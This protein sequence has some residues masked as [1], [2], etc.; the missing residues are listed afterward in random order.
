MAEP[1]YVADRDKPY[2]QVKIP[3]GYQ[4]YTGG[5]GEISI[6]IFRLNPE[7][8]KNTP[9]VIRANEKAEAVN[10]IMAFGIP[11]AMAR[12]IADAGIDSTNAGSL[13]TNVKPYDS[14]VSPA[15][16]SSIL[17][18]TGFTFGHI[19]VGTD[20]T[21]TPGTALGTGTVAKE[22]L[23]VMDGLEKAPTSFLGSWNPTLSVSEQKVGFQPGDF[24]IGSY[25]D[26]F[27]GLSPDYEG[28]KNV[29]LPGIQKMADEA[30][31][32]AAATEI[33]RKTDA[34]EHAG[35]DFQRLMIDSVLYTKSPT[36]LMT[37]DEIAVAQANGELSPIEQ[38]LAEWPEEDRTYTLEG[39]EFL[40]PVLGE[41]LAYASA[42]AGHISKV[43]VATATAE[44]N[45]AIAKQQGINDQAL[46][47]AQNRSESFRT[48]LKTDTDLAIATLQAE[49]D[50]ARFETEQNLEE[51]RVNAQ[52]AQG[53]EQHDQIMAQLELQEFQRSEEYKIQ[54]DQIEAAAAENL[55]R[56]NLDEAESLRRFDLQMAI[57]ATESEELARRFEREMFQMQVDQNN[58]DRQREQD[59]ITAETNERIADIQANAQLDANAKQL[60]ISQEQAAANEAIA[61]IQAK[62]ALDVA[63]QQGIAQTGIASIESTTAISIA[64]TQAEMQKEAQLAIQALQDNA[65]INELDKAEAIAQIQADAQSAGQLAQQQLRETTILGELD[66]AKAIATLQQEMQITAQTAMV[67]LQNNQALSE[68]DKAKA[69]AQI[70]EDTRQA[71][72]IAVAELQANQALTEL[73]KTEIIAGLQATATTT[74]ATTQ[75]G[76]VTGAAALQAE[77]ASPFGYVGAGVDAADRA[78][79]L[80][81]A[82]AI[83][84]QQ[85]NPYGLSDTQFT[86]MQNVAAQAGATPFGALAIAPDA[87]YEDILGVQQAQ[88]AAGPFQAAQLGQ[89]MGDISTILRGGLTPEQQLALAQA[90]GNPFG[91][92][93]NEAMALQNSLARG[94]LTPEQRLAEVQAGAAPQNM[95]NYLNFIGNPAAVGFAG[96]SGTLQNIADSPE[97][98]IPASLFGL[99]VPQ[100]SPTVP[101]NPTM[102]DLTDLTD[103]QL[104][105]YQG[106]MAAQNY[107]TPSQIFQQAQTV[108]PQGV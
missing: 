51:L 7:M 34:T 4:R 101:T 1:L 91:F 9:A 28:W 47:A 20:K 10:K 104:G 46:A 23:P 40:N 85:Y 22:Q 105:F 8:P 41:M 18:E 65:A 36:A 56:Y 62:G 49:V 14:I 81:D 83:L 13:Y 96:Q 82:Q 63:T 43:Q 21:F 58:V 84:G 50:Q 35:T 89:G 52:L 92:T 55:R 95:A 3:E 6:P 79:R 53:T 42:Q 102:A 44:G 15:G 57:A 45:L 77:A 75:A 11:A 69:I 31:K 19:P 72:N 106:Q 64:T 27:A 71:T 100:S 37:P 76:A 70:Q 87:R 48:K 80:T 67:G 30:N 26:A 78:Q 66:K 103:E 86:G 25:E 38:I 108:T 17:P 93:A 60:L 5:V 24:P 12:S 98:N 39:Q 97:G 54:A 74:A 107:Q 90:P 99:N 32:E 33:K 61:A 29:D 94:G 68:L 59:R 88:A 73:D 16:G 2:L